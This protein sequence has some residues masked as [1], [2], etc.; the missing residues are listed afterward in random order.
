M[1][2]IIR[3]P[4]DLIKKKQKKHKLLIVEGS[5]YLSKNRKLKFLN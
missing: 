3:R 4:L 1:N 5:N 2:W